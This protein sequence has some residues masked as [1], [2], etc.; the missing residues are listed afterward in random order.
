ML[1][2]PVALS[3]RAG[4]FH[5]LLPLV[6]P[7]D[8]EHPIALSTGAGYFHPLLPLVELLDAKWPS[9]TLYRGR[10]LSSITTTCR[11]SR[12]GVPNT[13]IAKVLWVDRMAL[14]KKN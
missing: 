13:S 11:T 7:L 6:E 3:T 12:S 10:I 14:K 1:N 2:G 5:P 4:Y 9:S 8:A